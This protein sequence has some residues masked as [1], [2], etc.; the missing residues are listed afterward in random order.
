MDSPR[1]KSSSRIKRG[2]VRNKQ[3][4]SCKDCDYTVERKS[5]SK[6]DFIKRQALELYSIQ[7]ENRRIES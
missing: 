4:Y 6:P 7:Y 2:F 3:R 5:T 1:C